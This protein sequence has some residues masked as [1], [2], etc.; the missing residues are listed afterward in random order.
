MEFGLSYKGA[1]NMDEKNTKGIE[2]EGY[3]FLNAADAVLA[4]KERK[5]IEYLEK[6]LDYQKPEQIL[7]VL[8]KLI[9]ERTFKTPVGTMYLKRLQDFLKNQNSIE[10]ERIPAIPVDF[11]CDKSVPQ[12]KV[13][14]KSVRAA[15]QR[16]EEIRKS[17]HNISLILN[18]ILIIGMIVM[19][20][21]ATQSETLNMIN[22]KTMLENRYAEWEQDLTE[23]EQNLREKEKNLIP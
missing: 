7:M 9:E 6:K 1:F 18:V 17:N 3:M 21:M 8:Q 12:T 10:R 23:R 5:Q 14:L 22:Y 4:E 2:A 16:R 19:F 13:E 11:V 20:W 15:A